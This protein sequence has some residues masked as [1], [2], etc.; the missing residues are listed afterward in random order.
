[1]ENINITFAPDT[2]ADSK[3]RIADIEGYLALL[4]DRLRFCL[5]QMSEETAKNDG[6][7]EDRELILSTLSDGVGEFT[8]EN[9]NCEIF[10]D[11]ENNKALSYYAHAE[12]GQTSASAPCTHAEG[13]GTKSTAP[14]GHAEGLYS[15]ATASY[16]HAEGEGCEAGGLASHAGGYYTR[17]FGRGMYAI[18]S[19]NKTVYGALL[20]AGNGYKEGDEVFCSDAF[21]LDENGNLHISGRLTADKGVDYTLPTASAAIL[22]GIRVGENLNITEDGVLSANADYTLPAATDSVLGGV[23]AGENITIAEDGRISADLSGYLMSDE[24][25]DWAKAEDKPTYTAKEV[26]AATAD[27]ITAAVDDIAIGGRNLLLNTKTFTAA[28]SADI[29]GALIS[30]ATVPLS[31]EIY[32][33]LAV[34]SCVL[35]TSVTE[36]CKYNCTYFDLGDTFTFSFFARGNVS[37]LR[38]YFY[39]ATGYAEVAKCVNSHG[40]VSTNKDGRTSFFVTPEWKRYIVT[41]TLKRT[42]DVTIPKYVLIRTYQSEAGQSVSVCGCKLERGNKATDWTPSPDDDNARLSGLE[43]RVAALEAMMIT[44]GE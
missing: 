43:E 30:E 2:S 33:D 14:C 18:G 37:E 39:G 6:A 29:N 1:M 15:K 19:F 38:V 23:M 25:S 20:V 3:K 12:G 36:I 41:W 21:V 32:R 28:D 40:E 31:A 44:D 8:D 10:N 17:A 35:T 42:G 4:S 9:K 5:A 13:Y 11:Y 22:G 27:D 24:I 7:N 16:A 26:G 34:R